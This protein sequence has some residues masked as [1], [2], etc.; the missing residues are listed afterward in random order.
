MATYKAEFLAHYYGD[1]LRKP[2]ALRLRIHGSAGACVPRS[3]PVSHRVWR[4]CPCDPWRLQRAEGGPRRRPAAQAA[5]V[6]PAQLSG[7]VGEASANKRRPE[8]RESSGP[9]V[10]RHVEQLLPPAIPPRCGPGSPNR[11][12]SPS[13]SRASTSAAAVRS[14]TLDFCDRPASYL[15]R[16]SRQASLRRSTLDCPSSSSNPAA[17]ASSATS[18]STSSPLMSVPNAC[19]N[20]PCC[21]ANS[22]LRHAPDFQ[23]PQ[24]HGRKIIL[25][26]HCHHKSVMKMADEVAILRRTGADVQLLD[27]GCCGMAGPFGFEREKFCGLPGAGRTRA[28]ARRPRSRAGNHPRRRWL[29]LPGAN[30]S[31][32]EPP[33]RS[34]RGSYRS[35]PAR[36]LTARLFA[37]YGGD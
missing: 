16:N 24:L 13:K 28:A 32:L 14:T 33:R 37:S 27:S 23:P 20:K 21:S 19:A 12:H 29:Q 1:R 17:P 6:R 30:Q 2:A 18:S 25:H 5:A 22:S 31:E 3:S 10:A 34:L 15:L 4:I 26:G 35:G 36:Q 8:N 7:R 11:R 9:S